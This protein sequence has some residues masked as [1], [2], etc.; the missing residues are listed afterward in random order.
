MVCLSCSWEGPIIRL[1]APGGVLSLSLGVHSP[2]SGPSRP[3]AGLLFWCSLL[4]SADRTEWSG[5]LP[6]RRR[7]TATRRGSNGGEARLSALVAL[8]DVGSRALSASAVVAYVADGAAAI[9]GRS[10]AEAVRD[11]LTWVLSRDGKAQR[12]KA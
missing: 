11:A 6:L 1:C 3:G 2:V 7:P 4:S 5:H 10:A 9:L 8:P 12:S